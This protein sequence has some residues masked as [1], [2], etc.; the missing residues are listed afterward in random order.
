MTHKL[1]VANR[2]EIAVRII[3]ACQELG[4]RTVAIYSV[5]DENSL[6]VKMADEAIC[7]GSSMSADSY[8]NLNRV[9]SAAVATGA[10]IV[11]P[12]YGFL[13]ENPR[14]AH[15]LEKCDI[16]F[17]GPKAETLA[18]VGDK[19]AA[20][21]WVKGLKIPVVDGSDGPIDDAAS[22]IEIVRKIGYPVLLKAVDGGGGKGIAVAESDTELISA[23]SRMQ[24]EAKA[25]FGT[26]S[27]YLET[28]IPR[29][30]HVEVQVM[31]DHSGNIVHFTE[32]DCSMQRH[33]QKVIEESP[34]PVMN[35][36]LRRNLA[37]AAVRICRSLNYRGAGTIEFLLDQEHKYFFLEM[38]ARIQVEHPVTEMATGVDLV[39]EQIL[40]ALGE[41]L[42][43][44]QYQIKTKGHTIECRVNA[45]DVF[46]DFMPCPGTIHNVVMP[47]GPGVRIDSHI[48]NG[49][50]VPSFYDSLLA[51]L[52]VHAPTRLEA[53]R[54]MRVA[55]AGFIIDGI[56]TNIDFLYVMMHNPT[57][58][59]GQYDTT[60]V[61][62][63]IREELD[64]ELYR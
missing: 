14:F 49:Y 8:L 3:R 61:M 60:F 23:F 36:L 33:N 29:A 52:I 4:I 39:K 6:H 12:G 7:I 58:I 15:M 17:V 57:F 28:Y 38:N 44:K 46:H 13:A 19:I 5:T 37:L 24:L 9:V 48:F 21:N 30:R 20:K 34:S 50:V 63:A 62:K 32:R 31:C 41:A 64:G 26:D 53:I 11:H 45:E 22:G 35:P 42:S 59:K 25:S 40:I 56:K 27:L 47:G 55:L 43:I 54:K 1:L 16:T 10:S 2:G 51:K 18:F